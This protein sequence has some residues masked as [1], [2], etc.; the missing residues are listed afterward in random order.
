MEDTK[1]KTNLAYVDTVSKI[2][3]G[4]IRSA[5]ERDLEE[6]SSFIE[7][8]KSIKD[9]D[10]IS[11]QENTHSMFAEGTLEKLKN[12]YSKDDIEEEKV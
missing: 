10:N 9:V 8:V 5:T 1:V 11:S 12:R 7:G 6:D 3:S 4:I 2:V